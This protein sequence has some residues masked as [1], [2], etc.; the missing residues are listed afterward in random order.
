MPIMDG[1]E[2]VEYIKKEP[3]I[4]DMTIMML[5]S[6]RS[7][8]DIARC[9]ELGIAG[10]LVKPIKRS[11]LFEAITA[12]IGKKKMVAEGPAVTTPTAPED[13]RPLHILLVEDSADNRLL[14]QSYLKKTPYHLEIAENG[15]IA[16]EKFKSGEY[17]LVLMDMQMP[18]MDGYEATRAIREAER[19][20]EKVKSKIQNLKSKI[21]GVPIIALTAY[22]T[23]EEEQKSLDAG[24]NAHLTKPIKKA[25]LMEAI[26]EYTTIRK[27]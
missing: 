23:K 8:G 9:R 1:F 21:E 12:A 4:V 7:S 2:L 20:A 17:D 10:Y 11:R 22:A 25:K 15:E 26:L 27:E 5:T 13:L 6:D 16:V 14:I 3:G 19:E 18:V 24:C